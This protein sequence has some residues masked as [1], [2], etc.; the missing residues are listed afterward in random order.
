MTRNLKLVDAVIDLYRI[1]Q[2]VLVET[3]QQV[4]SDAIRKCADKLHQCSLAEYRFSIQV[5]EVI[6]KAKE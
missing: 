1:A 4:L 3:E 2:L 5:E 6:K